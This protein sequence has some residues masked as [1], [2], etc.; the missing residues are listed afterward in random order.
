MKAPMYPT[1]RRVITT[2]VDVITSTN[3]IGILEK[4]LS[5]HK[6]NAIEIEYLYNYYKGQ[7]PILNRIKQFRPE[8]NNKIVE[9]HA[10]EIVDFKKG[11]IFG[12]PVQYVVRGEKD[13][14]SDK[15]SALN[16]FMFVEDKSAEDKELA[17]WFFIAGSA[18]RLVLPNRYFLGQEDESPFKLAT[19]D[20]RYTFVVYNNK[21][22]KQPMF[23]CTYTMNEDGENVYSV[24]TRHEY[25]Q[26]IESDKFKISHK[27][28]HVLNDTP[29]I[30]Y[31]A[32]S[33]RLG[34]FETVLPL[35]DGINL[36]TSNRMDGVEQF[37]QSFLK[38]VNCSIDD[39]KFEALREMGALLVKSTSG[40]PADVDIISEELNQSQI[41]ILKDDLY[42]AALTICSMP[43]RQGSPRATSDTGVAVS[44]RDGWTA[45]EVS[46]KDVETSFKPSDRKFLKLVLNIIRINLPDIKLSLSDID[47]KF[48]RNRT[49]N[50]LVKVQGLQGLLVAGVHPRIALSTSGLFSDPEQVYADSLE[51]LEKW[52]HEEISQLETDLKYKR[53]NAE[54][55]N[56]AE[57]LPNAT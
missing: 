25:F 49:D 17:E 22:T 53:E 11:H 30:E 4:A 29:I 40:L 15:L 57:K 56:L 23:G 7:Q 18:Y 46:A 52:K 2:S 6:Q 21:F 47:I 54:K 26:I 1:G 13:G 27:E 16:E 9:N 45:A 5:T 20:P 38:F 3:V 12:E 32:N 44:L 10:L 55:H 43:D 28:T 35:L 31:Y 14:L 41:Q 51:Y 42:Q 34:A 50:F 48:T 8:I 24:Y 37:V 33:T 39:K 19:L 36:L